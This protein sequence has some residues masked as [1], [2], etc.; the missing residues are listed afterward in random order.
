MSRSFSRYFAP[1][2]LNVVY[3]LTVKPYRLNENCEGA[4]STTWGRTSLLVSGKRHPTTQK[5]LEYHGLGRL[6]SVCEVTSATTQYP[7]GTCAQ[8]NNQMG[9]WTKYSSELRKWVHA[10]NFEKDVS[11]ERFRPACVAV[12]RSAPCL[13]ANALGLPIGLQAVLGARHSA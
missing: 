3:K 5:Q 2:N 6:G 11:A 4:E 10:L 12:W 1:N 7:S 8:K 13:M 9:Y